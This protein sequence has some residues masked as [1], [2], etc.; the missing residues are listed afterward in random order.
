MAKALKDAQSNPPTDITPAAYENLRRLAEVLTF[1]KRPAAGLPADQQRAI[2][3]LLRK[4]AAQPVHTDKIAQSAAALLARPDA[5]GGIVLSGAVTF[6]GVQDKLYGAAVRMAGQA[7]PV[8]VLSGQSLAVGKDNKVLVLG[9]ILRDPGKNL[10]GY[11]GTQPVVVW[12]TLA[13]KLP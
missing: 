10:A 3:D 11:K 12:A 7:K 4:I 6:V 2:D 1:V 8:G 9:S 5:Q 13:I